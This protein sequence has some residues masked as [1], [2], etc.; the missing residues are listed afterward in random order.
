[1]KTEDLAWAESDWVNYSVKVQRY[2][3]DSHRLLQWVK[4]CPDHL[5]VVY[6]CLKCF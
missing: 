3:A 6:S 5:Y 1:M 2:K 4:D